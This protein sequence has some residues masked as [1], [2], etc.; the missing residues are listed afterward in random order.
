MES[1]FTVFLQGKAQHLQWRAKEAFKHPNSRPY[2]FSVQQ[3][4]QS[5]S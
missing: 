4:R 3:F 1:F 2:D 5:K